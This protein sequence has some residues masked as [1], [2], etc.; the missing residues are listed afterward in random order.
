[1]KT[2]V[3]N[4]KVQRV[5]TDRQEQMIDTRK[6]DRLPAEFHQKPLHNWWVELKNENHDIASPASGICL[7]L[8]ADMFLIYDSP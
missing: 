8:V 2:F 1:M 4:T 3:K 7:L 5:L 6:G